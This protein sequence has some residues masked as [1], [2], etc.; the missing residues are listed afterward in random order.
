MLSIFCFN[1]FPKNLIPEDVQAQVL[2]GP[3]GGS[4]ADQGWKSSPCGRLWTLGVKPHPIILH[5][6]VLDQRQQF[7]R[8]GVVVQIYLRID[9]FNTIFD[10]FHSLGKSM[11]LPYTLVSLELPF[12]RWSW[13][14]GNTLIRPLGSWTILNNL[15]QYNFS[16][17]HSL[18]KSFLLP[19][20]LVFLGLDFTQMVLAVGK[21]L[22]MAISIILNNLEQPLIMQYFEK[23]ITL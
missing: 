14:S 17:I 22:D 12:P 7:P 5:T 9:Y 16:K 8:G 4:H 3:V 21:H 10:K 19:Y 1:I 23:K 11:L 15:Y 13:L 20:T 2:Q 18:G 6:R